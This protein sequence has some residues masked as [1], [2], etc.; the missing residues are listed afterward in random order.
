M[1][2][3]RMAAWAARALSMSALDR[4]LR[5]LSKG[6]LHLS[7]QSCSCMSIALKTT[8]TQAPVL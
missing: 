7:L 6:M 3:L 1:D 5:R 4:P 2:Q 8:G